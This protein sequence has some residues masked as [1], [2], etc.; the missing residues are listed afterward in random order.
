MNQHV[1]KIVFVGL[2]LAVGLNVNFAADKK[3][4]DAPMDDA[5]KAMQGRMMEYMTPN[6]NHDVLKSLAGS[7]KSNVKFWMDPI[8]YQSEIQEAVKILSRARIRVLIFNHQLCTLPEK[9]RGVAVKSISD[10]KRE[11]VADCDDCS[12][13]AD[14]GGFFSSVLEWRSRGIRPI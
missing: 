3:M 4:M 8:D 11:Y 12:K 13:R 6:A 9:I 14:C 10:W 1:C 7:W 2:F 5:Q